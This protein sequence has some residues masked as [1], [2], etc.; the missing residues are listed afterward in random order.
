MPDN[1]VVTGRPG[2]GKTTM[3]VSLAERFAAR[4][5]KAGGFVTEEIREGPHRVGF[6]VRDLRGDAAVLAHIAY[7]GKQRVGKYG[8]DTAAFEG[9]AIPAMQVGRDEADLLIIDE[10]GRM[11]L[12]SRHFRDMLPRLLDAPVPVLATAQSGK[13][14]FLADILARGDVTPFVLRPTERE[15]LLEVI[16]GSLS[17]ILTDN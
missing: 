3:V 13:G 14:D 11:E 8:V 6:R 12:F 15:R 2:S 5:F 17:R 9:V 10:I 1:I 7:K 16:D 4:G